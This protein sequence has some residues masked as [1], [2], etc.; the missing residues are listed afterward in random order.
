MKLLNEFRRQRNMVYVR[1]EEW[2]VSQCRNTVV[3]T[4]VVA[5]SMP[6]TIGLPCGVRGIP[7]SV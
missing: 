2:K 7:S 3:Q 5:I 6:T 1:I 4:R